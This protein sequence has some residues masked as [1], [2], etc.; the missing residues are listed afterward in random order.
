MNK[1]I[2]IALLILIACSTAR[3]SFS[4]LQRIKT[5]Q[6]Q[7]RAVHWGLDEGLSH[8][9]VS[10]MIQDVNGF[11]WIA[12]QFGLNRFDGDHFK[13]YFAD[14]TKKNK[15]IAGH[16]INGLIEDSLHNIW[17]GTNK[18]ISCYDIRADTFRNISS[19]NPLQSNIPFWATKDEVFCWDF[20]GPQLVAFNIHSFEKRILATIAATDT[21]GFGISAQYAIYD[22]GSNSVWMEKSYVGPPGQGGLLQLSL[23]NGKRKEFNWPCYRKIPNHPHFSEGMRYD[24]KRNSIWISSPDGL[25]EFTLTDKEFHHVDALNEFMNL[26]NFGAWAGIDID[27]RGRV[28]MGTEPK[29]II[30]Y[31]PVDNSISLPFANDSLQQKNVSD[32]LLTIYC[33]KDGMVWLGHFGQKGIYQIAPFSPAVKRYFVNENKV[34]NLTVWLQVKKLDLSNWQDSVSLSVDNCIT[35]DKGT[36]WMA[37]HDGVIIFNPRTGLFDLLRTKDLSGFKGHHSD[38][39][40][41]KVDTISNKAWIMGDE[42]FEMDI[43]SRK[44]IPIMYR[45]SNGN[46]THLLSLLAPNMEN[47]SAKSYKNGCII[48]ATF[49]GLHQEILILTANDPIARKILSF[50]GQPINLSSVST[51]DDNL[52]FLKRPDSATNL[53]YVHHNGAWIRTPTPLDSVQWSGIFYNKAD[54]TYWIIAETQLMHYDKDLRIIH[55]YSNENGMPGVIIHGLI[56]DNKGNIWFNTDR[57]IFQLNTKSGTITLLTEKDGFSPHYFY[58][59][60]GARDGNGDIFISG[61][62][63]TA[64]VDRISPDKYVFSPSSVYLESLKIN[65][66][67]FPVSAGINYINKLSLKYSENNINIETGVLDYYSKGN[68]HI[69]YKLETEGKKADWQ[70][71]PAYS[72]VRYQ[73]LQPGNYI[74]QMQASNAANEFSGPVKKLLFQINPPFWNTWWFRAIAAIFVLGTFYLIVR[75]R[76][77]QRFRTQLERSEK[78]RQVAELQQQKTEMEM[79]ALRAQ[80]NPHFIFNSLNSINRFILQNN[81]NQASEYLTKFSKLVRMILQNSQAS[82]ISLESELE[83]LNLYLD[84]EAVRFDHK[85]EYKISYPND[86]DI[87]VLKVPPL[88]IQPYTENAIWHGLMHKEDK[89]QLDINVTEA[90]DHLYIKIT[91][92]GIGRK[93]AGEI[94]SKSATKHKSMGLRITSDR[95]AM[96]EKAKGGESL[97]KVIDLENED[98]SSAGTEVIIMM[99]AIY[100]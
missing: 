44:C 99:P 71:A 8:D 5:K 77:R 21:V 3:Q 79:Q 84:L 72:S 50:S 85:F 60:S 2:T 42:F 100:E 64:G 29:G 25:M 61:R 56:P 20:P 78:D 62:G 14:K 75:Y 19:G 43:A 4:Q 13:K 67:T 39:N 45:D 86:L 80:M 6:D 30:V 55:T 47:F 22:P 53:T 32:L 34:L 81:R 76:T 98:G 89:G 11:L 24:R 63:F 27:R 70:Y 9:W 38:L 15:T 65:R 95:I 59:F 58:D 23:A 73:E 7:Y 10:S 97:V 18:G 74:L 82:L 90:N 91:D 52:I 87:E 66:Q 51:N 54:Q 31:D 96:L 28:W 37:A 46:L 12:S 35:G 68:G 17:I 40:P 33:A 94:A 16:N 88:I 57:S 93:K 83:S 49:P 41:I 69:R 36:I 48:S 1:K 26:K 92:N